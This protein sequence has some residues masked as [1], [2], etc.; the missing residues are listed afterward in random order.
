MN[1]VVPTQYA[2][3]LVVLSYLISAMGSYMALAISQRIQRRRLPGDW[4]HWALAGVALGGIGVWSMHF[5]G[6][7]ALRMPLGLGY[8]MPETAASLLAAV[9]AAGW[10]LSL[11]AR[12]PRSTPRLLAAGAMLGGGAAVMHYLGMYGMRFGGYFEW[13]LDTVALSV[14]VALV[15]ATAALWLAFHTP[16]G[17]S[18]TLA[19]LVMG[20][21]VCVMHYT[22]MA[23]ADIVCTT[24]NRLAI[25]VGPA[26]LSVLQLPLLVITLAVGM[27]AVLALD[28]M[29]SVAPS[30]RSGLALPGERS[31]ARRFDLD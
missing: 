9:A 24:D 20:G 13:A 1:E 7:L 2:M 5:I 31:S 21:A 11:V 22:G 25:P 12:N 15:A 16:T 30:R 23:A 26:T 14:L 17:L 28:L 27:V 3:P 29:F 19:A 10:G 4:R 18:R 6:M 8:S